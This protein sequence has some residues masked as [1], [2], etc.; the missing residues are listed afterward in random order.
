MLVGAQYGYLALTV[1]S[2]ESK[3]KATTNVHGP[4]VGTSNFEYTF[5]IGL[6]WE[7]YHQ[8]AIANHKDHWQSIV[9]SLSWD[10]KVIS[11]QNK[12][13]FPPKNVITWIS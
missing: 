1:V 2:F 5:A 12:D 4:F 6:D 3:L 9:L 7:L 11:G 13:Y 10:A 8:L